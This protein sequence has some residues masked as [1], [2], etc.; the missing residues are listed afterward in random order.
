MKYFDN[1]TLEAKMSILCRIWRS[2]NTTL[3]C[4]AKRCH[5]EGGEEYFKIWFVYVR[6]DEV[7]DLVDAQRCIECHVSPFVS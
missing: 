3:Y 7:H 4:A 1:T 2:D 6:I 5:I